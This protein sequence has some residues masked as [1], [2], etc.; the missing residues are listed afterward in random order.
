LQVL[1]EFANKLPWI[2]RVVIS[3]DTR[4][5]VQELA[6]AN[7]ASGFIAK[8]LPIDT[9]W[10]ALQTIAAGGEWWM[11]QANPSLPKEN[12]TSAM[13]TLRQLEVLALI[14]QGMSNKAIADSLYITERTVKQHTSDLLAR[15]GAVNRVQ[16]LHISRAK[17]W[18]R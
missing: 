14:D 3:G 16:L 2:A 9:V 4:E 17:G 11:G 1:R 7:A 5:H 6:R 12:S 8:T 13:F 10:Q 18:L 15:C